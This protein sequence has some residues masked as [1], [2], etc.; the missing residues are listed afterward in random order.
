M[1]RILLAFA[2]MFGCF[3]ESDTPDPVSEDASSSSAADSSS[4][5]AAVG[6]A[7]FRTTYGPFTALTIYPAPEATPPPKC[8][9]WDFTC[10]EL[11]CGGCNALTSDHGHTCI[12][13]P[14]GEDDCNCAVGAPPWTHPVTGR[15]YTN[16][17]YPSV[18]VD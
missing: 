12:S 14:Q 1:R 3:S 11:N 16:F 4:S 15:T 10:D 5:D 17:W 18:V 9:W 7:E 13:C 8:P 2:L 6:D